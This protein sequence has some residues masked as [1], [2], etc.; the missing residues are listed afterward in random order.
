MGVIKDI[1][2]RVIDHEGYSATVYKDINGFDTIAHGKRI[3]YMDISEDIAGLIMDD[4]LNKILINCYQ[5]FSWFRDQPRPAK[6]VIVEMI[7]QL[8]M[9]GFQKFK[10]TIA[11]LKA[12][13]YKSAAVEMMDSQWGRIHLKRAKILRNIIKACNK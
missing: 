7:Y 12:K 1:R 2:G 11:F 9:T 5:N 13:D 3:D 6:G 10:K 4:D 8:G